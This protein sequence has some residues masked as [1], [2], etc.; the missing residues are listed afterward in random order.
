MFYDNIG[1][2]LTFCPSKGS[3]IYRNKSEIPS[4]VI[5]TQ[6]LSNGTNPSVINATINKILNQTFNHQ[7]V[8]NS[9]FSF[10]RERYHLKNITENYRPGPLIRSTRGIERSCD[11]SL[12]GRVNPQWVSVESEDRAMIVEGIVRTTSVTHEDW[13]FNHYSHDQ[14]FDIEL[15][16][17]YIGLASDANTIGIVNPMIESEWEIDYENYGHADRLSIEI[18]TLHWVI[19]HSLSIRRL[20]TGQH[21]KLRYDTTFAKRWKEDRQI[22]R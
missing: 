5:R 22:D 10:E 18:N 14:N 4:Q 9:T 12:L 16:P 2:G 3:L 19:V 1:S 7:P 17:N 8:I 6:L 15:D 20:L 21:S 13:P 11:M